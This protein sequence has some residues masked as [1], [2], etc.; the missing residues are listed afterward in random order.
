M[1]TIFRLMT[2][3]VHRCIGV[4]RRFDPERVA[5]VIEG[6]RVQLAAL[7]ELD[8]LEAQIDGLDPARWLAERLG[9]SFHF[10]A[11]RPT[12]GGHYGNAIFS[13]LPLDVV[14]QAALPTRPPAEARAAQWARVFVDGMVVNVV[15]THLGL[16]QIERLRQVD[17]LL[18]PKW[19]RRSSPAGR[20]PRRW[21]PPT[22]APSRQCGRGGP[23]CGLRPAPP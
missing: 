17:C 9:M 10:V 20:W 3:N 21:T 16:A 1:P 15:N 5:R 2:Y 7:Q 11:A 22:C 19:C 13:R 14:K 23:R 4:D 8:A 6:Q 18:G 12:H